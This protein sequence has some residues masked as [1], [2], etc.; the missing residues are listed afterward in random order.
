MI[1][2]DDKLFITSLSHSLATRKH[3]LREARRP[4]PEA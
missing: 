4:E 2:H 1:Y 3:I